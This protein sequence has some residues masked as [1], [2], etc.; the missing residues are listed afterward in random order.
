VRP[1]R[2]AAPRA[3]PV[4]PRP[5]GERRGQRAAPGAPAQLRERLQKV[6]ARAG[7]GSR[8]AVEELVRAGRVMINGAP[9]RLGDSLAPGDRVRV[10]ERRYRV[11]AAAA[12]EVPRLLAYNKPA[13]ELCTRRDERDRPTVFRNLPP[14]REGRWI[15]IGRLDATTSGLLLFT[16]DGDLANR[17]AHPRA[18]LEREYA[19]RVR[20]EATPEIVR[21]L[22]RGVLL[23]D[24]PA[25]F[26][27]VDFVGGEGS[28]RWYN[29]VIMEGRNREVRRLWEAVGL[30]VS[31][32]MRVRFGTQPL[33]RGLRAGRCRALD[34]AQTAALLAAAGVTTEVEQ[35]SLVLQPE[36]GRRPERARRR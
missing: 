12:P 21:R 7:G 9:A 10:D 2:K 27:R 19:V 33:P 1:R 26:E 8:R 32:L 5:A 35:P 28:N 14:L 20:G 6:L 22:R 13:G 16:T 34:E 24:G 36:R 17:L 15:N 25:R 23:D 4:R 18:G 29:V 30:S 11:T 3:A 31:R